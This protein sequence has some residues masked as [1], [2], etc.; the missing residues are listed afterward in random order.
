[1]YKNYIFDLYG[2]LVD[3][4]T[5]EEKSLVWEKLSLFYSYNNA[6]YE[7]LEIKDKYHELIK[8]Y[9]SIST[10]VDHPDFPVE[11]IFEELYLLKNVSPSQE[12]IKNTCHFFRILSMDK[13]N[14]YNGVI[15]L[16]K[17][18]KLNN[19]KI[20]LLTN[21]QKVFTS[22]EI[23]LLGLTNY[24]DDILY[25]S[26][27]KV[28]KPNKLFFNELINKHNLKINESIMIGNDYFCDI[29]PALDLGLDTLYIHSNISPDLKYPINSTYKILDGNFLNVKS[30]ILK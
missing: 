9:I 14:L 23:N 4:S 3:I 10:T 18:L 22:Y 11:Y 15:D 2:T 1:M 27:S 13:L 30:L 12:L 28:C 5:N 24:F 29:E 25:S 7:T 8:K 21:A 17:T 6:P 19:K 26:E 16:L 20:Y